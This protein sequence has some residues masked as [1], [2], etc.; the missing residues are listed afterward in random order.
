MTELERYLAE[1]VVI[2]FKDGHI[3]R[4]EALHRLAVMGLGAVTAGSMLA[5]CGG[6]PIA[7][8]NSSA[9]S[10]AGAKSSAGSSASAHG[11]QAAPGG[12]GSAS[13]SASA[14]RP[15]VDLPPSTPTE[16][17]SFAGPEGRKLQGAW[18]A[19]EK[20]KGAIIVI[21]ENRG[22]ND[23]TRHVAGRFAKVGYSAFAIDLLSAE[24]GTATFTDEAQATAAL[25][26]APV[27]R[28]VADLRA[29]LDEIAKRTPKVKLGAIGFCFGGGLTWQLIGAK[30]PR[31]AAAAPFYGPFPE[32]ADYTGAKTAVLGVYA[33]ADARVNGTKDAAKAALEKAKMVHEIVSFPG[34]HAFFNDTRERYNDASA[35]AAWS[36]VLEWFGKHIG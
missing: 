10:S 14:A 3:S 6:E 32:K 11:A 15:P 4:R 27:E 31:L 28:H 19:A 2:D 34:D 29:G 17:I 22:L 30:D 9:P 16:A 35:K 1:E 23:H 21:H 7:Q 20:P 25:G 24:G 13:A 33:D 12:S 26:K 18:A 8:S 36:K 5:A